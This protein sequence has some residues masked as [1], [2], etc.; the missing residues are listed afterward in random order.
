MIVSLSDGACQLPRNQGTAQQ[1]RRPKM[2]NRGRNPAPAEVEKWVGRSGGDRRFGE[3]PAAALPD[4]LLLPR[5]SESDRQYE[6]L[7]RAKYSF[8]LHRLPVRSR[9]G[10]RLRIFDTHD[11]ES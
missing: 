9:C 1:P 7:N 2:R 10:D 3:R 4:V 11:L 8:A 5:T 6:G